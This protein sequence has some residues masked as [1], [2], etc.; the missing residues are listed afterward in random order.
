MRPSKQDVRQGM[1]RFSRWKSQLLQRKAVVAESMQ[2]EAR[3]IRDV[4]VDVLLGIVREVLGL[5][6]EGKMRN[7]GSDQ[8][9][10]R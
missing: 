6:L 8:L 3:S 9:G 10:I 4:I 2:P 1:K 5:K 7:L